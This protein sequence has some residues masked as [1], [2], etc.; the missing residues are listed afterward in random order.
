MNLN[1]LLPCH[2]NNEDNKY[3]KGT[4]NIH[5]N[6]CQ[7][8]EFAKSLAYFMLINYDKYALEKCCDVESSTDNQPEAI[9]VNR[10]VSDDK[11]AIEVKSLH[12]LYNANIKK[13][14]KERRRINHFTDKILDEIGK[15]VYG[16]VDEF[17]TENNIV[18]TSEFVNLFLY[19]LLLKIYRDTDYEEENGQYFTIPKSVP[20]EFLSYKGKKEAELI[21]TITVHVFEYIIYNIIVCL[22][23]D[24]KKYR[25]N[26]E[27]KIDK[28]N[29]IIG[30]SNVDSLFSIQYIERGS[31]YNGLYPPIEAFGTRM[32]EYYEE[33]K[34]KF[35]EY[36]TSEYRRVLLITNENRYIKD[37]IIEQVKVIQKPKYIDDVWCCFYVYE[38]IW[39]DQLEDFDGEKIVDIE[40]IKVL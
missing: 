1:Q 8:C 14:D 33:C 4:K 7:K 39:N 15:R 28:L 24:V 23:G 32:N 37:K 31:I 36:M 9:F 2:I 26:L 30:K 25:S 16:K 17:L 11:I 12:Q 3:Y 38:E 40:Y 13:D 19:G 27:F 29:F 22:K 21:N 35:S 34:N 20:N 5:N 10:N 18:L 6:S